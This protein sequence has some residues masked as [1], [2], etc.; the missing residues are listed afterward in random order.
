MSL[1]FFSILNEFC[2][3]G[4]KIDNKED[5]N[6][7]TDMCSGFFTFAASLGDFIGPF[8]GGILV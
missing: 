4:A 3:V 7:I 8:I 6:L 1:A 2:N 5:K